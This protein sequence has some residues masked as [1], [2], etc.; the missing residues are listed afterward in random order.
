MMMML[1]LSELQLQLQHM[2]RERQAG[3]TVSAWTKQA[4]IRA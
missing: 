2:A 1:I 3:G 4:G